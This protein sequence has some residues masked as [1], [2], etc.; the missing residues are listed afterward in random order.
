MR[1]EAQWQA[2]ERELLEANSRFQDRARLAG[3]NAQDRVKAWVID[4]LGEEL[5]YDVQERIA[6]LI[7]EVAELSVA[8]GFPLENLIAIARD[9]YRRDVG[10]QAQEAGGVA[11]CILGYCEARGWSARD[12]EAAEIQR[13]ESKSREH[14][15]ARHNAKAARGIARPATVG[16]DADP[17][18]LWPA[19]AA[20]AE[21]GPILASIKLDPGAYAAAM[22]EISREFAEP[23]DEDGDP[24]TGRPLAGDISAINVLIDAWLIGLEDDPAVWI[25]IGLNSEKFDAAKRLVSIGLAEMR[26]SPA[27]PMVRWIKAPK[28]SPLQSDLAEIVPKINLAIKSGEAV[29]RAIDGIMATTTGEGMERQPASDSDNV[30]ERSIQPAA[31]D[32]SKLQAANARLDAINDAWAAYTAA[33][34]D[35]DEAASALD[36]AIRGELPE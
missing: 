32:A 36:Y 34:H 33:S 27:G 6:R 35:M 19:D 28:F 13:I 22:D 15:V 25:C 4:R 23:V 10:N 14:F 24:T 21:A 31:S 17:A 11:V 5:L 18:V 7:E 20:Q 2:R 3:G 1:T 9:A 30:L 16:N 29:H 26:D 12:L 8:E